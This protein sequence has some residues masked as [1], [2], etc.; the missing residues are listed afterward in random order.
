MGEMLYFANK[1]YRENK[2]EI[3]RLLQQ[4]VCA[5]SQNCDG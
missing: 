4:S 2:N 1:K 3:S 5:K